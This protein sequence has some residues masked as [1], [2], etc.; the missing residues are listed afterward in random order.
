MSGQAIETTRVA[1]AYLQPI[2]PH[3]VLASETAYPFG[4]RNCETI[5][6]AVPPD[7]EREVLVG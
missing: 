4:L 6:T 7:V 5:P 2:R 3:K 1:G